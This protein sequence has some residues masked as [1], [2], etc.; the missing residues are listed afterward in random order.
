LPSFNEPYAARSAYNRQKYVPTVFETYVADINIDG[1]DVEL[2]LW[3]TAGQEDY[4]R[5]RPLSYPDAHVILI[6][7]AIDSVEAL[8]NVQEMVGKPGNRLPH[9]RS[10]QNLTR[11]VHSGFQRSYISVHAFLSSWSAARL[12]SAAGS[13]RSVR[14]SQVNPGLQSHQSR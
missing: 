7:F 2:A 3:D 14:S 9:C 13:R 10:H 11:L 5:L 12:I 4:D 8:E 6:C 1:K